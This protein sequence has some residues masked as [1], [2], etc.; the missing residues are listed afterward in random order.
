MKFRDQTNKKQLHTNYVY[1][2]ISI[3]NDYDNL[4]GVQKLL[5]HFN[6]AMHGAIN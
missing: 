1:C 5:R 3:T 4:L 2:C 6:H